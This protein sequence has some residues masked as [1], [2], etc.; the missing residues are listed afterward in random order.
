MYEIN[1]KEAIQRSKSSFNNNNNNSSMTC[2]LILELHTVHGL[3][4]AWP[5]W[6]GPGGRTGNPG[7]KTCPW[8]RRNMGFFFHPKKSQ[9]LFLAS[10]SFAKVFKADWGCV[11]RGILFCRAS[12][13]WFFKVFFLL[14]PTSEGQEIRLRIQPVQQVRQGWGK[15]KTFFC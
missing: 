4:D 9:G 5:L 10:F 13:E 6:R 2:F 3:Q 1:L 14:L 8:R 12:Q 11:F 15:L 7:K